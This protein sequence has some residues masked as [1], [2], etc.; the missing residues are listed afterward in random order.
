VIPWTAVQI[1]QPS[2][3]A[4]G[5]LRSANGA[6]ELRNVHANAQDSYSHPDVDYKFSTY[7]EDYTSGQPWN[8][9]AACPQ[10]PYLQSHIRSLT[11]PNQYTFRQTGTIT[12]SDGLYW[13]VT[14]E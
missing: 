2:I 13:F 6:D 5:F 11:N 14:L 10:H 4:K 12:V 9:F 7:A 1:L 3:N 8:Y